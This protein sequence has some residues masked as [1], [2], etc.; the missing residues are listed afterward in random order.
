M[1][2]MHI[3]TVEGGYDQQR[4]ITPPPLDEISRL[5]CGVP[6]VSVVNYLGRTC[7]LVINAGGQQLEFPLNARASEIAGCSVYGVAIILDKV[8]LTDV[9]R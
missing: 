8:T 2:L 6:E 7:Q 9:T 4:A 1:G 5:V 3:F